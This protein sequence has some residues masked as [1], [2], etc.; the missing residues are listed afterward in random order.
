MF[1]SIFGNAPWTLFI[2]SPRTSLQLHEVALVQRTGH[3]LWDLDLCMVAPLRQQSPPATRD[4]AFVVS[5]LEGL[6]SS[7]LSWRATSIDAANPRS[8][9][10]KQ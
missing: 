1:P 7:G 2:G 5:A 6:E 10:V 8:T 4:S 3:A 9:L